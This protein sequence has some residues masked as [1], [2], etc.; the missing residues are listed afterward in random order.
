MNMPRIFARGNTQDGCGNT[1]NEDEIIMHGHAGDI[2]RLAAGVMGI[3]LRAYKLLAFFLGCVFASVAGALMVHYI[4]FAIFD[5]FPF[6]NSVWQSSS[7]SS[8]SP[9][10]GSPVGDGQG[11]LPAT[12]FFT[13]KTN[14]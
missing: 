13:L 4:A 11:I 14:I 3:N 8:L 10:A 1:M 5:Q 6:M 2:I 9:R 7:S 12:A